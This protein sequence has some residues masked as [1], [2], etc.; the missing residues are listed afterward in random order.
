MR[1]IVQGSSR[2]YS[3]QTGDV[4]YCVLPL[5][6]SAA[7]ATCIFRSLIEGIPCVIES[8][9]SVSRFGTGGQPYR[10]LRRFSSTI[11]LITSFA[12]PFG[13]GFL[14]PRDQ[15]SRRYFRCFSALWKF[16]R[17]DGLMI[18]VLA[19]RLGFKNKNKKPRRVRSWLVRLGARCR[20]LL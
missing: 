3:S 14:H 17:V 11:A 9:F 4:I 5:F 20:D 16:S 12:G 19:I 8:K 6:N 7:W 13:P 10:G 18:A 2:Q 1:S 15:Y